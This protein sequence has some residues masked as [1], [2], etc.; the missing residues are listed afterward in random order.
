MQN[1]IA[2]IGAGNLGISLAKGLVESGVYKPHQFNLSRRRIKKL[3]DL[4]SLGYNVFNNNTD[5]I[6]DAD[7]IVIAVLPQKINEILEELKATIKPN[8]LI[9]SLVSGVEIDEISTQLINEVPIIRAMPN[10]AIAIRE[11]MTCI[12]IKN[13]WKDKEE[14]VK[15]MFDHD[16]E[17]DAIIE[18]KMTS[19]TTMCACGIAVFLRPMRSASQ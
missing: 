10:T 1:K 3:Q 15:D 17:T 13:K 19:A 16:G 6:H 9:I 2:I 14:I 12:A 7:V 8:K 4:Q 18:E 11:S 5:A